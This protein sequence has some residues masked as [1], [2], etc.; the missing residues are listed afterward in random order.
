M[1]LPV[2]ERLRVLR[3]EIAAIK[4][5][6]EFMK[7]QKGAAAESERERRQQRLQEIQEELTAMTEWKK[8]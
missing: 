2:L 7:H 5:A 6:N 3:E 8:P 1:P 4:Q